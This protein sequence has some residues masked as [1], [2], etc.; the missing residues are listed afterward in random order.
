MYFGNDSLR[1]IV[2]FVSISELKDFPSVKVY[3]FKIFFE[4]SL[5]KF[6]SIKSSNTKYGMVY[7]QKIPF[8]F[9]INYNAVNLLFP[10]IKMFLRLV[11]TY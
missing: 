3:L 10:S 6:F 8:F 11:L 7:Y 4:T 9:L 5:K 2:L 1:L